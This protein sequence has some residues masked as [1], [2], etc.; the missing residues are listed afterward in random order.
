MEPLFHDWHIE[1]REYARQEARRGRRH[2][3]ASVDPLRTALIVIDMVPFFVAESAYCQG[4]VPNI[5][6]IAAALRAA[7]GTVAWVLPGVGNRSDV[8]NEFFGP[9][10]AEMFRRS[11]G[12][13]PLASRL[14]PALAYA[15]GDLLAEKTASSAFFPGRS[16]LPHQLEQ[17]GITTVLITGTVTNVCCESSA[18]DASTLGYRVIMVADGNAARR[19]QDHNATLY[20]VYRTFGDVRS[21][22]EVLALIEA[23]PS[24]AN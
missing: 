23:G 6:C 24:P 15:D 9:H 2:A 20:R 8:A 19:D 13:G 7:R 3:Y 11:G 21:T 12:D 16:E 14:W 10:I 1:E 4:I 5:N 18:R 22:D 17:R